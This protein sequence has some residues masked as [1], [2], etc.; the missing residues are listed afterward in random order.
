ML[1]GKLKSLVMRLKSDLCAQAAQQA[2]EA[3]HAD[4]AADLSYP[5]GQ[6]GFLFSI[7]RVLPPACFIFTEKLKRVDVPFQSLGCLCSHPRPNGHRKE[8]LL[9]VVE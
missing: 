6:R 8:E 9:S 7:P 4:E 2:V 3:W 1:T 5:S